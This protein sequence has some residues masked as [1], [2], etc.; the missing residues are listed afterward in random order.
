MGKAG[1][2]AFR[3]EGKCFSRRRGWYEIEKNAKVDDSGFSRKAPHRIGPG[4][5][6]DTEK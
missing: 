2:S 1:T 4:T 3:A 6:K 5:G